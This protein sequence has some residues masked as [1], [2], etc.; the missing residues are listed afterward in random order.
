MTVLCLLKIWCQQLYL[1]QL[2]SGFNRILYRIRYTGLVRLERIKLSLLTPKVSVRS[3]H[4]SLLSLQ[5]STPTGFATVCNLLLYIQYLLDS[6]Q[7]SRSKGGRAP[8]TLRH[9]EYTRSY[10]GSNSDEGI[11]NPLC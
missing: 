9:I 2:T 10:G 4:Y 1:K 7:P 6:N 8:V 11:D 3:I 5:A